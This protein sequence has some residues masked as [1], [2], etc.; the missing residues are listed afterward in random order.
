MKK[1]LRLMIVLGAFVFA[2]RDAAAQAVCD[3][4]FIPCFNTTSG[5]G[6]FFDVEATTDVTIEGFSMMSQ[7]SGSRDLEIYTKSGTA[8]G[9]EGDAGPWTRI[10]TA[11]GFD[12]VPGITCP[13]PVNPLP[14]PI[15]VCI[16]S[17][18]RAGFYIAT[19]NGTG[20]F[21]LYDTLTTGALF[22]D[23][24]KIKMYVGRGTF[25]IGSFT[26]FITQNKI[27]QG[28]I[29][30]SCGCTTGIKDQSI[31]EGVK[32]YPSVTESEISL[33]LTNA[34]VSFSQMRVVDSFGRTVSEF[35][36][37]PNEKQVIKDVSS[38][39]AG[40]YTVLLSGKDRTA[41][42]KFIRTR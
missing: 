42:L 23:D 1:Q 32:L 17:G 21:E 9:F 39:S 18:Q 15:N 37:Q 41:Q 31:S 36:L 14:I 26:G 34:G 16:Q 24:S 29:Q 28:S 22:S 40:I 20:T 3:S 30:Y 6:I 11:S 4:M 10:G 7:N 25:S 13:L 27:L 12:P 2:Q 33:D 38:L 5:T 19:V 8:S 35:E